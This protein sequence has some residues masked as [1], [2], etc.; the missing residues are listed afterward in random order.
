MKLKK[1]ISRYLSLSRY[2]SSA[3]F[4]RFSFD[5][6][7]YRKVRVSDRYEE[8][9]KNWSRIYEYPLV[10][11]KIREHTATTEISI[12]NSSWGFNELH[13]DFKGDL[14]NEFKDVVNSDLLP[15]EIPNTVIWDITTR[16]PEEY[17]NRFDFVLN[18]STVEEVDT[19]HLMI[20]ENLFA[21][22]KP[23][24][25]LIMTF[26]LPG[27]QLKKLNKLLNTELVEF[28]DNISGANSVIP[29]PKYSHLN[30]GLLVLRR[31]S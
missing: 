28:D 9:Y 31:I 8:K 15:S 24:G 19:D 22:V 1:Y 29:L 27:M 11:D 7:E 25:F 3:D 2:F 21:Q 10:I 20:I 14:E 16:P 23:G 6:V 13:A 4:S 30:C 26:D 5:V 12:H 17:L 18:V